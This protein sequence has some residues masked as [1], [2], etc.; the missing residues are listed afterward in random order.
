ME[1]KKSQDAGQVYNDKALASMIQ[2]YQSAYKRNMK[3]LDLKPFEQFHSESEEW[4]NVDLVKFIMMSQD[5]ALYWSTA[6]IVLL[7]Y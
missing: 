1:P 6:Q 3:I 7:M 4:A 5:N 2:A